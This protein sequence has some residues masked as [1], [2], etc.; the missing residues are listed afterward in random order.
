LWNFDKQF[1]VYYISE[2]RKYNT[3]FIFLNFGH[4]PI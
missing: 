4:Y 2:L 3:K 1:D